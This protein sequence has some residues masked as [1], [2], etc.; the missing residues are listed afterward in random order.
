MELR[1]PQ[2]RLQPGQSGEHRRRRIVL[3]LRNQLT[4]APFAVPP[5]ARKFADEV[6]TLT[7]ERIGLS[8]RFIPLS[9]I[10]HLWYDFFANGQGRSQKK[11]LGG[12]T[13]PPPPRYGRQDFAVLPAS[14]YRHAELPTYDVSGDLDPLAAPP[15]RGPASLRYTL[16]VI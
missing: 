9:I 14:S 8:K 13:Q 4:R 2:Q 10:I 12:L 1:A 3:L 7:A 11:S 16:T 6:R 5:S 15:P